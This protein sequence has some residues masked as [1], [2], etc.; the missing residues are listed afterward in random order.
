MQFHPWV[1]V[2]EAFASIPP[3]HRNRSDY[4]LMN[5]SPV[6]RQRMSCLQQGENF[7]ALPM[8]MRPN[9]WKNGKHQGQDTFGRLRADR[10]S[11]TVRTAAYNPAKGMYIHPFENRGL[12]SHEMAALQSFPADWIFRCKGSDKVTLVSVGK[13]IGNA[14]PP[15]TARAVGL[16]LKAG[17]LGIEPI[18]NSGS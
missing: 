18:C 8:D 13:Q 11:V 3:G 12:S 15:L 6:V 17:I 9:C 14:V 10:P 4:A 1:T 5:I 7:K 2:A 16:A